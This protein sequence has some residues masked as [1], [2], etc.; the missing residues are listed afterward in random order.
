MQKLHAITRYKKDSSSYIL[1]SKCLDNAP[2]LV[3][4]RSRNTLHHLVI[5][6]F[7]EI[8]SSF[9]DYNYYIFVACWGSVNHRCRKGGGKGARAP[10]NFG[11]R[12]TIGQ[13]AVGSFYCL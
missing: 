4:F 2:E 7:T 12:G 13:N 10:Q 1:L 9:V 3:H 11:H 5:A 6:A 8:N